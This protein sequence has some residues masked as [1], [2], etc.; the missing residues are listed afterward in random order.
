MPSP[1]RCKQ[2]GGDNIYE[3]NPTEYE[4]HGV[5]F[6]YKIIEFAEEV[7]VCADCNSWWIHDY[8][9]IP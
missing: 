5:D 8:L 2:C 9:D 6:D 1:I 4:Q 3:I 7:F